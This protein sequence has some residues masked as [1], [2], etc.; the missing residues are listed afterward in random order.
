MAFLLDDLRA[1]AN[2][3]RAQTPTVLVAQ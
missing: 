2:G 3:Q 1:A